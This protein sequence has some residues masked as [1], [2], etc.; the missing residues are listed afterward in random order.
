[1]EFRASFCD[2]FNP[3]IVELGRIGENEIIDK[4]KSIPWRDYLDRM[5]KTRE[6]EIY[7][8]PSLEIEN[9]ENRNGI[10][11]SAVDDGK[12]GIEYY[13]FYKRPKEETKF[14]GLTKKMNDNYLTEITEQTE[15]DALQCL[16]ALINNKLG[17][18][19][20]KIR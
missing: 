1:M 9:T 10:T 16:T 7:Y 13:I 19:E 12:G 15:E 4:F 3:Q 20:L 5:G 2:P 17:Y 14:F 18:L 8:S 11:I 6:S